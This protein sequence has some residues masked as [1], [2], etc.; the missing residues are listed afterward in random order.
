[1]GDLDIIIGAGIAGASA[2]FELAEDHRVLLLEREA[3][4][5]YHST[6]RSAALYTEIY[7]NAVIRK[8]AK[9]SLSFLASPP[10]GFSEFP[11]LTRR[12]GLFLARP[13]QEESLHNE[14]ACIKATG[15]EVEV[16]D[17]SQLRSLFPALKRGYATA[18]LYDAQSLDIDVH[19]LHKGFLSAMQQKGG[20]LQTSCKVEALHLSKKGWRVQTEKGE[21]SC[22]ILVNA[23][24][25]WAGEIGK[26][27]GAKDIGLV[28][29]RRTA[30]LFEPP[31]DHEINS[32]PMVIDIDEKFYLKPDSGKFLGSPADQTPVRPQDARPQDWDIALAVGRMQ[33]M[34]D[35]EIQRITHKWAGLRSFVADKTPVVGF[36]P[37]VKN[38]FW[39]AAQGG[40]GIKTSPALASC[41]GSLIRDGVLPEALQAV[42]LTEDLL[43]PKRLG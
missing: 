27:A 5:G 28:P 42:G 34:L 43:S 39:L 10:H 35:F 21:F 26:Q 25:A 33:A 31:A 40:Y 41:C 23:A 32:W 17:E 6:G 2:A 4:A 15:G 29:M 14:R 37:Q 16:L 20:T 19:G 22:Q 18:G 12:G 9:L 7:G 38:F 30:F 24:G 1:M 11:L 13:D 36:D 3:E 8:L